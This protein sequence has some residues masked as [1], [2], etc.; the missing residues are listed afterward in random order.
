MGLKT[1]IGWTDHSVNFWAGCTKISAGCKHCYMY[2]DWGGRFGKNPKEVV[3]ISYQTIKATLS[4]AKPGDKIFTCSFS[5]FFLK[6]ADQYRQKAWDIIR[7]HP[8]FIWQI[9]TKRPERIME[10]LPE[11]WGDGWPNVW[12]GISAEN[13]EAY[14]DRLSFLLKNNAALRFVSLEPLLG[15]IDLRLSTKV[16]SLLPNTWGDAIV[17]QEL[18]WVIVGGE[19]GNDTGDYAG[20]RPMEAS[21]LAGIVRQLFDTPLF[22]KQM[23]TDLARS[24][25][26]VD[27]HGADI[28]EF[29]PHFQYQDFPKYNVP[30]LPVE[31]DPKKYMGQYPAK[32]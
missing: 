25:G 8:Q 5:D 29:P 28:T 12:L 32:W 13:Q 17:S 2:R 30:V 4:K 3:E 26:L 20:H 10:C 24:M 23:G 14:D 15:D 22:V 6:E 21:W 31:K 7:A 9:L 19:S 11:D 27:R 18:D 16:A 1:R